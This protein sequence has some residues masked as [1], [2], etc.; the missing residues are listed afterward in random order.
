M[1][2]TIHRDGHN[3]G[4]YSLEQVKG[5]LTS[6]KLLAEDIAWYEG[7]AD[8]LP[9]SQV[10]GIVTAQPPLPIQTPAIPP[11]PAPS[12]AYFLQQTE[13]RLL[14]NEKVYM[15]GWVF[16]RSGWDH[17]A[18]CYVTNYRLCVIQQPLHFS[19]TITRALMKW[20]EKPNKITYQI[21]WIRLTEI[22]RGRGFGDKRL[23][24]KTSDGQEVTLVFRRTLFIFSDETLWHTAIKKATQV[25]F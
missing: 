18:Y 13:F 3:Y 25:T 20:M 2:I 15:E 4:P 12:D 9:L 22:T 24:F 11:P 1:S 17:R 8:W 7:V 23:I 21:P 6:G 14:Q 5:Y 16:Y 19:I 10:P